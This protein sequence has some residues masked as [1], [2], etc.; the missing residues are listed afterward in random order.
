MSP[1]R[2]SPRPCRR[3]RGSGGRG[4]PPPIS[5]APR[6]SQDVTRA[7]GIRDAGAG[8]K[9]RKPARGGK[10]L[11]TRHATQRASRQK[12][13]RSDNRCAER[14]ESPDQGACPLARRRDRRRSPTRATRPKG[15][16]SPHDR[17]PT[18]RSRATKGAGQ[19]QAHE[20]MK[21]AAARR[22]KNRQRDHRGAAATAR[23]NGAKREPP[24]ARG[25]GEGG[26]VGKRGGRARPAR[27]TSRGHARPRVFHPLIIHHRGWLPRVREPAPAGARTVKHLITLGEA[28]IIFC[29][30]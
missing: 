28:G 13:E 21:Q 20:D 30:T 26:W 4:V 11:Q 14:S 2:K 23:P 10:P 3:P 18:T 12:A 22:A 1:P 7:A 27:G 16:T 24:R 15:T 5:R 19:A 25:G 8:G 17:T 29:E 6:V 9:P